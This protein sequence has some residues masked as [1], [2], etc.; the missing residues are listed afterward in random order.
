MLELIYIGRLDYLARP[1]IH[2]PGRVPNDADVVAA[3]KVLREN[4]RK[5]GDKSLSA[6]HAQTKLIK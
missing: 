4:E 5:H 6:N 1:D 3:L 2:K